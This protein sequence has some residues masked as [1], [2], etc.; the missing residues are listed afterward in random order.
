MADKMALVPGLERIGERRLRVVHAEVTVA[1]STLWRGVT[2]A[3]KEPADW[4]K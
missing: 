4:L 2:E 3:F 1:L